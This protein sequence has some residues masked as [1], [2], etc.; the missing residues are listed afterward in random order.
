MEFPAFVLAGT[1]TCFF[2]CL[3][4]VGIAQQE[5]HTQRM[6]VGTPRVNAAMLAQ[7]LSSMG[8]SQEQVREEITKLVV[9][10]ATQDSTRSIIDT[11]TQRHYVERIASI[12][13]SAKKFMQKPDRDLFSKWYFNEDGVE[14][15]V[16]DIVECRND[17]AQSRTFFG[18]VQATMA[19]TFTKFV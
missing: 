13:K 2:V 15:L 6:A 14:S 11:A 10:D 4:F 8:M 3:L 18:L 1:Q 19:G 7:L 5:V 9:Q 17:T 16:H 12:R